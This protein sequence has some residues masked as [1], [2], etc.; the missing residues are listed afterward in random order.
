M[1]LYDIYRDWSPKIVCLKA[2][3]IGFSTLA[4]VKSIWGSKHKKID[5]IYTLPTDNDVKAFAGGK[6]NRIISLNPILQEYVKERDTVEQKKV[7]DNIIYYRG[8]KSASAAIMV[9]ADGLIHD[10]EDRSDQK[11][12]QTYSSRLQASDKKWEWHFS[13]PSVPG[14]GVS[15]YW[16]KST[17]SEWF[18]KCGECTKEQF[19]E[20][21][22]NIDLERKVY[23]CKFCK[24]IL[25]NRHQGRWV[26]RFKDREYKGYH[27][28]LLMAPWVEAR[29]IVDY[30]E[31]KPADYFANFV[32]GLPY[33]GEGNTVTPETIYKNCTQ[34]TNDQEFSV[35]GCDS[36]IIK[37]YTIGNAKGLFYYGK[38]ENWDDIGRLLKTNPKWIAVIDAMPDITGPRKLREE[39]PG[40]VFLCHYA[41]DRKT[42]Q[43]IRWGEGEEYGNVTVDRNRAL[44]FL[45]DEFAQ[46]LVPLQG[47]RDDWEQYAMHWKTLY[48][49]SDVDS[50]GSPIFKWETSTG[51]DHWCH[52]TL[53]T[54]V[55]IEKIGIGE[56]KVIFGST[57]PKEQE[58]PLM[59]PDGQV[60]YKTNPLQF[61]KKPN[62]E[63]WYD[64]T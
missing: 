56:S 32:L 7:G 40:R 10:E 3:Q 14:N 45:I 41:R 16:E 23:I 38:T 15:R 21:P 46:E 33:I 1:F 47:N 2:A 62:R 20:W 51:L 11:V 35:I 39:F 24:M 31:N 27:I 58:A 9:S 22:H 25:A 6:V 4:I 61:G 52:A 26:D 57:G 12:I 60:E 29:E 49:I 50:N 48:R 19:L 13:N 55:G 59:R 63:E 42:M 28:S 37:H 44:Q 18:I 43:L 64:L 5:L 34:E 8:T 17:Q 36:G 54:R 30:Y 53:Y